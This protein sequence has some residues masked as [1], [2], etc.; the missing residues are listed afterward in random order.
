MKYVQAVGSSPEFQTIIKDK[1]ENRLS[2]AY[3]IVSMDI[4]IIKTYFNLSAMRILCSS[5]GCQTCDTCKKILNRNHADIRHY[6]DDSSF[7]VK[8]AEELINSTYLAPIEPTGKKLYFIYHGERINVQTQNKLLKTLEEPPKSVMI[9]IATSNESLILDTIKSRSRKIYIDALDTESIYSEL[10]QTYGVGERVRNAANASMGNIGLA[11]R[12]IYDEELIESN[13]EV[14]KLFLELN[15]SRD[16]IN[17]INKPCFA[18]ERLEDTLSIMQM[19]I[20]DAMAKEISKCVFAV[21]MGKELDIIRERYSLEAMIRTSELINEAKEKL[22]SYCN[23]I[24]ICDS[25][26]FS[27]M[28]VRYKCRRS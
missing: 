19:V 13:N 6:E 2:H 4:E 24:N 7:K 9:F 11:E 21:H 17:Y 28:E 15:S 25:L 18:K 3:L 27:I 5:G 14:W 16:I 23:P 20:R 10:S 12:L 26:L 22:A 8:D 1:E